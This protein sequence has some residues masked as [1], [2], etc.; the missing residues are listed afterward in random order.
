MLN[1]KIE[2]HNK[3]LIAIRIEKTNDGAFRAVGLLSDLLYAEGSIQ[4]VMYCMDYK[5]LN[6]DKVYDVVDNKWPWAG[7][8]IK[9]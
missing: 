7:G 1:Y 5:T 6:G 3:Y 9:P 2:N 4:Y 8:K